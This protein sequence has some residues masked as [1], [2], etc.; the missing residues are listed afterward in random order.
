LIGHFVRLVVSQMSVPSEIG[1]ARVQ[2]WV[3]VR[4][5]GL[6]IAGVVQTAAGV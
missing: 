1:S 3:V 5:C 6:L 4:R 2:D